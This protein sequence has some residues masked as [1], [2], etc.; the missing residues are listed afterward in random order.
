MKK[1][2]YLG[3]PSVLIVMIDSKTISQLLYLEFVLVLMLSSFVFRKINQNSMANELF[4]YSLVLCVKFVYNCYSNY[5]MDSL[6]QI[7]TSL[8][9]M[10][11][12]IKW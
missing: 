9:Y 4:L 6:A 12:Q 2:F 8:S 10:S 5:T 1:A 7:A 3:I 11:Y